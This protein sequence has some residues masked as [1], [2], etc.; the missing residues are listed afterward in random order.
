MNRGTY[1]FLLLIG[2]LA[3]S[4]IA[5]QVD[6]SMI[7]KYPF[8]LGNI[9]F[10]IDSL[11]FD[12]GN[13]TRGE[14]FHHEIQMYNFGKQPITF[15]SG[16]MDKFVDMN[17]NP[18]I[19][20]PDQSG[21]AIIDFEVVQDLPLGHT[22][23]EI[24]IETNDKSNPFK[25]LYLIG[26]VTEDSPHFENKLVF[27]TVPR[28]VF[29]HY[30]YNFGH[31]PRGKNIVHTFVFTNRGNQDLIIDE[32]NSSVGCSVI[33]PPM[34]IIPPGGTGTLV[35]KVRML[36]NFGVQHR[37][38][39]IK[40]NDPINPKITLGLHG[41]VRHNTPSLSDPDFCYQ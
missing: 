35:V 41:T 2:L 20:S 31:L 23:A 30:N 12:V 17:Y 14:T 37:T 32:I 6:S 39:N 18:G 38:I 40:T 4:V 34:T 7:K 36:G 15:K 26:N 29:D 9:G 33:P 11:E 1:F 28:M 22:I 24:A 5:Q 16:K 3:N 13:L 21:T 27:D 19:L 25:F 8:R 10:A